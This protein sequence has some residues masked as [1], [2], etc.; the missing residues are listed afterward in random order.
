MKETLSQYVERIMRQKALSFIDVE[1]GSAGQISASYIGR[2]LKG[3][4]TNLTT[5]KIVALAQGLAVDPYDIFSA[6][7][8]KPPAPQDHTNV[9]VLLD[10]MQKLVMNPEVLEAA[11]QLL[12]LSPKD[13]A[14]LLQPLKRINTEKKKGKEKEKEH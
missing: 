11:E 4:V 10:T 14:V 3:T 13:R 9:L 2:I 8:G 6:S 5:E 7:Y 1:R 12:R